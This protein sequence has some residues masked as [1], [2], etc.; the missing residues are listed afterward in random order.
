MAVSSSLRFPSE[1]LIERSLQI[2]LENQAASGAFIASPNFPTYAYCWFRD[3]SYIAY[4][5][6]LYGEHEASSRFHDWVSSTINRRVDVVQR[7]LQKASAGQP[8]TDL[9]VLHTRYTLDGEEN[10]TTAWENFQLD[11]FGTWLWALNEHQKHN[12][13]VP[14]SQPVLDAAELVAD[15]LCGL[16]SLPCYDCWEEFPDHIHPHTLAAIYGGLQAHSELTGRDHSLVTE[17]IRSQLLAGA[18]EFGHFVKFPGSP[19]VDASLLGLCVPYCV[20]KPDDT[21]MLRT[22]K[23]IE[24]TILHDGGLHR[25][26]KD[27]YFGGGEWILLSAWLGW[28]WQ[29]VGETEKA[30]HLRRW[31]EAQADERGWLPEQVPIR[32]NDES[33]YA[34][35]VQRWGPIAKPLLWSHAEYLILHKVMKDD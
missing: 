7:A 6:D 14:L 24:L 3:S 33:M 19:E 8:L 17:L 15:Y 25:Y 27:S 28:Y 23:Q 10:T 35:W 2:I 13:K 29:E 20:V 12:L 34:P 1:R 5:L 30:C 9:D 22:V 26:A 11:G 16:W 18:E 4:A 21:I 32:L 31:I